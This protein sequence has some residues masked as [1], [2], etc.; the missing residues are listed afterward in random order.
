MAALLEHIATVCGPFGTQ[1]FLW[2]LVFLPRGRDIGFP[3]LDASRSFTHLP[4]TCTKV[5]AWV[6][7]SNHESP[8]GRGPV[9][10]GL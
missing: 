5:T 8:G 10:R 3:G 6:R 7:T 9:S 1:V 4:L 2:G